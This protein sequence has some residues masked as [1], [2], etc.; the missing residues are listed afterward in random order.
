MRVSNA[1]NCREGLV[2][3]EMGGEIGRWPERA[4][5]NFSGEVGHHQMLGLHLVVRHAAGLDDDQSLFARDAANVAEGV[6][7]QAATNQFEISVQDLFAQTW[8]QHRIKWVGKSRKCSKLLIVN[9][10]PASEK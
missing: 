10:Y 2:E 9:V 6:Q 5:D 7:H 8:Q 1:P 4:F 3:H